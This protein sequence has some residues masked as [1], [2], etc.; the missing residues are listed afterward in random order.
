MV[1]R[2]ELL[3]PAKDAATEIGSIECVADAVY[4]VAY[5]FVANEPAEKSI[6]VIQ[7]KA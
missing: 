4:I 1:I 5:C 2:I 7:S 3:A 6:E